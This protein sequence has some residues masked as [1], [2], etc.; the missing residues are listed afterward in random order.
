MSCCCSAKR[1]WVLLV[2]SLATFAITVSFAGGAQEAP[3]AAGEKPA[4]EDKAEEA[5][6]FIYATMDTSMG[7][8]LIELNNAKAPISTA[9][10]VEY[11]NAD[12]YDGTIFH[13][14]IPTFMIQGGGFT[15][16]MKKRATN[17]PIKNEWENGLS[18]TRGTIAMARTNAPNSATNQFFINV[19]DN[20]FLDQGRTPGT[21]G[22]AVFGRVVDGMETVDRIRFVKTSIAANRMSDVPVEPVL[23]ERITI[24]TPEQAKAALDAAAA[25]AKPETEKP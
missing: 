8:V 16:D 12:A 2:L 9:N 11:A 1:F 25:K 21:A 17:A 15:P 5:P 22:Y 13:R 20:L 6:E 24:L 18:N 23:I 19:K 4:A 7:S 3:A 10:F 14:V